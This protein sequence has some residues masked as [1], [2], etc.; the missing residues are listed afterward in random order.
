MRYSRM[1]DG[2]GG[3]DYDPGGFNQ[4]PDPQT[5]DAIVSE[6]MPAAPK[7]ATEPPAQTDGSEPGP[8][9]NPEPAQQGNPVAAMAPVPPAVPSAIAGVKESEATG[10]VKGSFGQAG[11]AGFSRRFGSPAAWYKGAGQSDPSVMA[12]I[13]NKGRGILG[14]K[15]AGAGVGG[16]VTVP[17]V[18]APSQGA[19]SGNSVDEFWDRVIRETL[20]KR[21]GTGV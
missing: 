11:E 14:R 20:R 15:N 1:M 9:R 13:A 17:V 2:Q 18:G 10:G 19:S 3:W 5:I 8:A 12:D 7:V 4:E 21:F 16:G 6:P